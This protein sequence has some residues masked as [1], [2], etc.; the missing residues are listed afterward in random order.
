MSSPRS[1]SANFLIRN[2]SKCS[3]DTQIVIYAKRLLSPGEE[4]LYDY[5]FPLESDPAL[6]VP[7]LC[8][9]KICRGFLN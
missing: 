2:L 1:P 4:I 8:G 7:C 9:S 3:A 6:R 5:K